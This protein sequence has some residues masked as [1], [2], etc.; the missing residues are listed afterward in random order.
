VQEDVLRAGDRQILHL[1]NQVTGQLGGDLA[2]QQ[3]GAV[4]VGEVTDQIT[5]LDA[6]AAGSG[7]LDHEKAAFR[8][9]IGGDGSGG[10]QSVRCSHLIRQSSRVRVRLVTRRLGR[11]QGM[12]YFR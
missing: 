11:W 1:K 4:A 12:V 9:V 5:G 3:Q 2:A 10:G 6:L 8:L 7:N